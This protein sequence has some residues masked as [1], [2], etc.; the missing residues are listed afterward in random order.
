MDVAKMQM[1]KLVTGLCSLYSTLWVG[2][3]Q[4]AS[5]M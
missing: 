2:K 4:P 5:R 1:N 3:L